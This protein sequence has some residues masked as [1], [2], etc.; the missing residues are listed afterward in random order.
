[1]VVDGKQVTRKTLVEI[2]GH[3]VKSITIKLLR[4]VC[5]ILKV[6]GYKNK[7]KD[8]MLAIMGQHKYN[9]ELYGDLYGDTA[10]SGTTSCKE[11]Q[12]SFCLLNV[13]FSN[14]FSVCLKGL[15]ATRTRQQLHGVGQC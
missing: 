11:P 13:L 1:M 7:S 15:A 2:H 8:N 3:N 5:S 12:C 4:K 6:S 10:G 9:V 14:A